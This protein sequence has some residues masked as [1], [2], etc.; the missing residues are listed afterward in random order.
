MEQQPQEPGF[1]EKAWNWAKD[2]STL[3]LSIVG[4]TLAADAVNLTDMWPNFG[5]EDADDPVARIEA[6]DFWGR[7]EDAD[8]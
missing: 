2:N 5:E 1:L 8:A 6:L 7:P 4:A 3:L